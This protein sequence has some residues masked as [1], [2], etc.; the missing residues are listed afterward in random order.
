VPAWARFI[1]GVAALRIGLNLALYASLGP[2]P[3]LDPAPHWVFAGLSATFA[4]VGLGL[5]IGNRHDDRAAWLGGIFMLIASPIT[6]PIMAEMNPAVRALLFLSPEAFLG[7]FVWMFVREFPSRL[8][9]GAAAV[10]RTAAIV[11]GVLAALAAGINLA[12][13][14]LPETSGWWTPV[15]VTTSPGLYWPLTLGLLA[16]ALVALIWRIAASPTSSRWAVRLFAVGLIAGVLPFTLEVIVEQL[17]PAYRAFAHSPAIEPRI[18]AVIFGALAAVPFITTY[19]VLFERVVDVRVVLRTALQYALARYTIIATGFVPFAALALFLFDRRQEPLVE[20]LSS[21]PRPFILA[22]LVLVGAVALRLR[23]RWLDALDRR[24]FRERYDSRQIVAGLIGRLPTTSITALADRVRAEIDLAMHAQAELFFPDY[25]REVLRHAGDRLASV[26]VS[27]TIMSLALSDS[28]PMDVNL[29]DVTS[30]WR[31]LPDAERTWLMDGGFKLVVGLTGGSG[32]AV[33]LLA[34]T[35][36]RSGLA[37]SAED[38]RLLSAIALATGLAYDVTLRRNTPDSA[39]EPSA[40]ECASCLRVSAGNVARCT[41]GGDLVTAAVPHI[42]RG[43]FRFDQKIGVGGM[44]I[45]YRA[46]DL[47]L[48]RTVAIK[49]LP[50]VTSH[51]VEQLRREA[52]AM[53]AVSH[54]NLAVIHGVETWRGTAFLVQEHLAKGTLAQRLSDS[55]LSLQEA[56]DLGITLGRALAHAHGRG[57]IHLDIKPSNIGFTHDDMVK[58]F[59]FGVA[60]VLSDGQPATD[61]PTT[62]KSIVAVQTATGGLFGTPAYMSPEAASGDRP[63]PS[64]DLWALAVV[65]FEAITR[66]RPF[67]GPDD[68]AIFDRI[69]GGEIP[70]IRTIRPGVPAEYSTFFATALARDSRR[71]PQDATA[72][73]TL[74][75]RL[76]PG[77]A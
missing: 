72:M 68:Y 36:K 52:R 25:S 23:T 46:V 54:P 56:V 27:S 50:Q 3:D 67:D 17:V 74:L 59:D 31:R 64:F 76:P 11:S 9:G 39:S 28:D 33:G 15:L 53:A 47:N 63:A 5:V 51:R 48:G 24:Y 6:T 66:R 19:S 21:G 2:A 37:F 35:E 8:D 77:N 60:R 61:A 29:S 62:R 26:N 69:R 34:L 22:A 20:I 55:S 40:R 42:L 30:P 73:V 45:V 70:D 49:A 75:S 43:V 38:R 18:G 58:L 57:V 10:V 71:R 1:V 44:G 13:I 7:T 4:I 14:A 65:L 12:A 32:D 41:C 16:L